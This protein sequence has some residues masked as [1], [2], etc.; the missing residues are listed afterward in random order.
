MLKKSRLLALLGIVAVQP[1]GIAAAE[2][3]SADEVIAKYIEALGGR[4]KID[5]VKTMR[6]TGKM[7]GMG[8]LEIPMVIENKRPNK[9][10]RELNFQGM[11]G[12]QAYDGTTGWFVM[13]FAGRLEP[14]KM[15]DEDLK[16]M[17]EQ[18][19]MDGALVDYKKK[20]HKIELM[21]KEEEDGSEVYKLKVT[22]KGGD[23][24]YYFL[25]AEYFLPIK[26]KGSRSRQGTVFEFEASLGDYKEVNGL[27]VAHSIAQTTGVMGGSTV[28]FEK[29]EINV[30]LPD[31]RFAM[32]APK[33]E[34]PADT[35]SD[36][37]KPNDKGKSE[38]DQH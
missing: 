6:M 13:P 36:T 35:E 18:A 30:D 34:A 20:G 4:D 37:D 25:D 32:P 12:V 2:P 5:A 7:V 8:G 33:A 22:K 28:T 27:L 17:E 15:S 31:E 14:E 21:G 10:R 1:V 3:E 38:D 29:V 9:T 19:D 11:T 23:V 24:D 26:I 16:G